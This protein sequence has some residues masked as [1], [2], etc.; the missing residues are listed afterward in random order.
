MKTAF[1]GI[2][3]LFGIFAVI[4]AALLGSVLYITHYKVAVEVAVVDTAQSADGVY[5]VVLQSVGEPTWP[6]GSAPGRLVLS[7]DERIISKT[8]FEIANDGASFS[9]RDWRV[10]WYDDHVEIILSGEEQHDE[11]VALY[12]DGQVERSRLTTHRGVEKESASDNAAE[13]EHLFSR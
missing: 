6:F 11:L 9:G 12:Y 7:C 3:I 1:K 10:R 8:D 13:D 2:A 4:A 5:Q